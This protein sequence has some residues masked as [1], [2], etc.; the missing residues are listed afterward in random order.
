[1]EWLALGSSFF[2]L[3]QVGETFASEEGRWDE[4]HILCL[5]G[6]IFFRGSSQLDWAMWDQADSV[7]VRFWR[8]Q[9]DQLRDGTVMTHVRAGPSISLRDGGGA[10]EWIF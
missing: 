5:G 9:G 10:V 6:M 1:M 3:A 7:D 4:G 8:S 2:F